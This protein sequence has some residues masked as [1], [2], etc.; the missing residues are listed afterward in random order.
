MAKTPKI[1]GY[2][3]VVLSGNCGMDC[4]DFGDTIG[5]THEIAIECGHTHKTADAADKCRGKLVGYDPKTHTCSAQW[6]NSSI[7][8][9][10]AEYKS[11]HLVISIK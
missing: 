4:I 10:F 7:Q 8:P 5:R 2:R 3:V 1:I 6:Y 9:I 11:T